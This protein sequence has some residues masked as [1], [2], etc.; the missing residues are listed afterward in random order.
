MQT[1][2]PL[3]Y[4]FGQTF[5]NFDQKSLAQKNKLYIKRFPREVEKLEQKLPLFRGNIFSLC[6]TIYQYLK[7]MVV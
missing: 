7:E 4:F 1:N 3:L 2:S 6:N 5:Q